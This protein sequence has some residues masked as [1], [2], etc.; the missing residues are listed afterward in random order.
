MV[1]LK[2]NVFILATSAVSQMC[3]FDIN[4]FVMQ[5][6]TVTVKNSRKPFLLAVICQGRLLVKNV[7]NENNCL[8][9]ADQSNDKICLFYFLH[10]ICVICAFNI[11]ATGMEFCV[12]RG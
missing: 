6:S 7:K 4:A 10:D 5:T 1:N 2:T 8:H 9:L 3:K 12:Y 11:N